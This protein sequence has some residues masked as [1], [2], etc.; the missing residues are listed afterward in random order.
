MNT[1]V[2]ER[3]GTSECGQVLQKL[4]TIAGSGF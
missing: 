4:V 1:P 2:V 3:G